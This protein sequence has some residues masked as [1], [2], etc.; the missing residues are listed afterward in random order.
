MKHGD[1]VRSRNSIQVGRVHITDKLCS[2]QSLE[3]NE[4][5]WMV[6]ADN[7]NQFKDNWRVIKSAEEKGRT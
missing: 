6:R 2:I 7:V 4:T 3:G 5:S 1:I